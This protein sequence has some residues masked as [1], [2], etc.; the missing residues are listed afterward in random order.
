MAKWWE[1]E[2]VN[3]GQM[4]YSD[5][6]LAL[7]VATM[8]DRVLTSPENY[9]KN[10]K[11][12]QEEKGGFMN[13]IMKGIGKVDGALKNVLPG[14]AYNGWH[15][16][17]EGLWYPVDKVAQGA[18]WLYSE[19]VS[20]PLSTV[21][22]QFGKADVNSDYG[23]LFSGSEWADAYGK[24]ENISPG[25]AFVNY[26]NTIR[27]KGDA[28]AFAGIFTNDLQFSKEE[29]DQLSRQTERF[30]Y[31][32][33]YW[34]GKDA[35]TY[36]RGTGA[37][38]FF[39]VV[40][41]DPTA[42]VIG[43][44]TNAFKLAR[45]A[46]FVD[47]GTGELVRKTGEFEVKSLGYKKQ[48]TGK[49]TLEEYSNGDAMNK[50]YDWIS[51][52]GMTGPTKSAAEIAAH[53]IWGSGRRTNP[54]KDSWGQ[55]LAQASRE[56]MPMILRFS[57]GDTN[58]AKELAAKG[59][60]TLD[61]IGRLADNRKLLDST[62][63]DD[64]MLSYFAA[65][66][67]GL[68]GFT[69]EATRLYEPPF[70]RPTTPGPRQ[71]G[72]DARWG[73]L[74][75]QAQ[76]HREAV[77]ATF[78]GLSGKAAQVRGMAPAGGISASDMANIQAWRTGKI[79]MID[80]EMKA[81][82][83]SNKAIGTLLGSNLGKSV[84]ELSMSD[85][86]MFGTMDRA[87]RMGSQRAA[88][89][90]GE[91]G[92]K[93]FERQN[94]NRKGRFEVQNFRQG[95]YGTPLRVVQSFG[96]RAPQGRIN[97]NEDD[98]ADRVMDMLKQVPGL[99]PKIRAGMHD[100]YIM[101]G[102]KVRRSQQLEKIQSDIIQH[103]A[104]R[105]HGLDPEMAK[106]IEKM[107][108]VG[109]DKTMHDLSGGRF[110]GATQ[111]FS[112][113]KAK[114]GGTERTV[115]HVKDGE[116]WIIAP[117]AKSQLSMTDSLLPIKELDEILKRNS[118]S[119]R[120]LRK[121][122]AGAMDV[123]SGYTDAF[124]TLWK[125]ATLLRPAYTPRMISEELFAS[126]IK[127]GALSRLIADPLVGTSNF[128]RN[129]TVQLGAELGLTSHVPTTGAGLESKLAIIRIGD[130]G[131][132]SGIEARRSQI[133]DLL[134]NAT[135]KEKVQLEQ[136]LG[137]LKTKRLRVNKA[138]PVIQ[139]RISMER[140]LHDNLSADIEKWKVKIEKLKGS[141]MTTDQLKVQGFRDKIAV[142]QDQMADHKAVI[143][144]FLEYSD[145]ILRTAV[146]AEGWRL[147]EGTFQAFGREIPQAFSKE[148][149]FPVARSSLSSDNAYQTMYA[150]AEN[151]DMG[152]AIRTG[153]WEYI[154]PDMP[155]HMDAWLRG[156]NF[157][158]RQDDVFRLVAE[159]SSGKKA[160]EFLRSP[161]GKAHLA[162]LGGFRSPAELITA[163]KHTLDKYL[164]VESLQQKLAKG[165]EI[166]PAELRANLGRN[167]FPIVHGEEMKYPT[168][169]SHKDTA[170]SITD[171]IVAKGF[172]RLGSIPS[173]LMSRHPV[174]ARAFEA[175]YRT[176]MQQEMR[177]KEA[178]AESLT[179]KELE[180]IKNK[181]DKLAR[182]DISQ[183][184]YDPKRTTANEAL[185]F[186]FPFLSAHTDSLSR[187]A[188]LIA[189][190][191]E[192]LGTIA[193]IYN[194]PVAANLITDSQGN[195]VGLDGMVT[196]KVPVIEEK[197]FKDPVT[198][199][200]TVKKEITGEKTVREM[201]TI[202]DRVFHLRN[203]WNAKSEGDIPIKLSAM[204]TILPG[205]PWFNPGSGPLVQ[206]AGSQ[207]AK[208]SP[209]TGDFLQWAKILP[210]GPTDIS[211]SITPKYM[212]SAWDAWRGDDPDNE[213]Y[214]KAYLAV[215]NRKVAEFHETG[216]KFTVKDVEKEAQ[217]FLYLSFLEAWGSPAQ[218][219]AT[220][221]T[222]TKYQ[223]FVD[224]Y[225]QLRDADPQNAKD[226]FMERYGSDYFQ[227]T[228]SLTKSMG[229]AA[230]HSADAMAQK[231]KDLLDLDPE[232][233]PFIIGNVYNNG[234]FSRSVYVKQL[235]ESFGSEWVREKITAKDAIKQNQTEQ[236]W[237]EWN[238]MKNT[239][240]SML[241]RAGF[242][243]YTQSGAE[244]FNQM[245][246]NV[247][248]NLGN[249]F[250]GWAEA[251]STTDRAKIPNRVESFERLIQDE[252]F[253]QD[254]MRQNEIMN[255]TKY[256]MMRRQFKAE[257][258]KRGAKQLSFNV[259]GQP[260]GDNADL[261]LM[262]NRSVFQLINDD[263]SFGYLYNRYLS[264]DHLQ[265]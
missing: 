151:V 158:F 20:Q 29:Q 167:E 162:D 82:I 93:K 149:D 176:F 116:A 218:T 41:A 242:T 177:Y 60:Q 15:A 92:T 117:L 81:L 51:T 263:T 39:F 142:A 108:K 181:A 209:Q 58:A 257:L 90:A 42:P 124:S 152:R 43:A 3:A 137:A 120:E 180:S 169:M 1:T 38:D 79:Q 17:L 45:S 31:D 226:L 4:L 112:G 63:F 232:M 99:D 136:E 128:I 225:A 66:Q 170:T 100:S 147:G 195:P 261:A 241:I 25:Q 47:D 202:N 207:I 6:E 49:Q 244:K 191:P 91:V 143:D 56:E 227:F 173:D 174:Y 10:L 87:F 228:S 105:V 130:E 89:R 182:K 72:W 62:K 32:T 201:V 163:V 145:E 78:G 132:A 76:V 118:G 121:A 144:E 189:E 215:Y 67:E 125:A 53:P 104:T 94:L 178:G 140:E 126:A 190:K 102:D 55:A 200:V 119:M 23:Q 61:N 84:D 205:D 206:I 240:D 113:A 33:K 96:D 245:R 221:I 101:A 197:I 75:G 146:Q 110:T 243:S 2:M 219:Q 107:V 34:R 22:L 26:E 86:H 129:R 5:P 211:T 36:N 213:E 186:V 249:Q 64:E 246:A 160:M 184:V 194:A 203:P 114:L 138:M 37:L 46:Q 11:A 52:P 233:A 231:Y 260:I 188:G 224:A 204:N 40:F 109:V 165:E 139:N 153:S 95:F 254:P 13:T 77:E 192:S 222:G 229:I 97:H 187:W 65:K 156:I 247:V 252:R 216:K 16:T 236:G 150:R 7:Q 168:S 71:S 230:T 111:A 185:R 127:F 50:F 253:Q 73:S 256:L 250:P 238:Q 179:P 235:E 85:M 54:F 68:P 148:W 223:F 214:Q 172:K 210:Y 80:N 48:F 19:G 161:Q 251:Y 193:K 35:E 106:I 83:G 154:T 248:Q 69:G 212:R 220:P 196:K 103:M 57:M 8:P 98:A 157:Q 259:A 265:G 234:A 217:N 264:N 237:A 258:T 27:A 141:Q 74:A 131:I 175:R 30:L 255:L 171:R 88:E 262:W 135:G 199:K 123:V 164:P 14:F 208:A 155:N 159:D 59:S 12:T 239:M 18:R 122:G 70:P 9:Q 183:V 198:G 166:T 133:K 44:A 115:D 134:V 24:A 21:F 28:G